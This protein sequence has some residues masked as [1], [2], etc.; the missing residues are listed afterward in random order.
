MN[1]TFKELCMEDFLYKNNYRILSTLILWF[2]VKQPIPSDDFYWT[3]YV[4]SKTG[5]GGN[6]VD[7]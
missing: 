7:L 5:G 4:F 6:F 2:E 1:Q 3:I